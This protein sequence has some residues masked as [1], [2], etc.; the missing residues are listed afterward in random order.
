MTH[1]PGVTIEST[2]ES[3]KREILA[4]A[5]L[6]ACKTFAELHD[7]CDANVLGTSEELF[8]SFAR[9][10][11]D[12]ITDEACDALNTVQ[13]AIG[14]WLLNRWANAPAARLLFQAMQDRITRYTAA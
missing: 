7:H 9:D 10:E 5:E 6:A 3:I 8:A 4:D 11:D 13:D 2:I 12:E 14:A 1:T